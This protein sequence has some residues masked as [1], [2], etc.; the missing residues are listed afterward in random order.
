M[1]YRCSRLEDVHPI[2][3]AVYKQ[4]AVK[5]KLN[6]RWKKRG[7]SGDRIPIIVMQCDYA[8]MIKKFKVFL[9]IINFNLIFDLLGKEDHRGHN[10]RKIF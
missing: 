10:V 3:E 9:S 2:C 5:T 8:K 4:H 1:L 7:R 6:V